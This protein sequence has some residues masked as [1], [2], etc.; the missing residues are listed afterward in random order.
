MRL[1]L[2]AVRGVL[3]VG[4][5]VLLGGVGAW[6][7]LRTH[8]VQ[9]VLRPALLDYL[10][11]T[12]DEEQRNELYDKLAGGQGTLWDIAP[13]PL[14]GRLAKR[15]GEFVY[16]EALVRT[17]NAGMR[18]ARPYTAKSSDVFRIVCLGDSFV[19][20]EGGREEDRFCN[21][22][23]DFYNDHG[24]RPDGRRVETYALGLSSWTLL[25]EARYLTRSLTAYDPDVILVLTSAN[26]ITDAFGVTGKGTLTTKF[27]P[28]H[29]DWGS[30][31][32][33]NQQGLRLGSL[34][35][36]ALT[37]D[38]SP[39]ARA[40]WR[41][42]MQQL[43]ELVDL[44]HR[45]GKQILLSLLLY[46]MDGYFVHTYLDQLAQARVDAPVLMTS[47]F[48]SK[49]TQLP[50][51]RHP[52]RAGHA[53]LAD[54]LIH[55]LSALGWVPVPPTML[56]PLDERLSLDFHHA[57]KPDALARH[58]ADYVREHLHSALDFRSFSAE[59]ARGVLGGLLL[60][61]RPSTEPGVWAS[62]RSA[63]LLRRGED[64]REVEI[65][66]VVPDRVE[67][68]PL[69]IDLTLNGVPA[70]SRSIGAA[71]ANQSQFLRAPLP[72]ATEQ[73]REV[74][75][76]LLEASSHFTRIGD[77]TMRSFRLLSARAF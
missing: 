35:P 40:R 21:Q 16:K 33:S 53:I 10:A 45:R 30:A 43:A 59:D 3:V 25:Q 57:A 7:A 49:A 74:V 32:F 22:L 67:L 39:E 62:V 8:F 26:D 71:E 24:I 38:L 27:S 37:T 13:D 15:N 47:F 65:E 9:A 14:V 4:W 6:L 34:E 46:M 48:A 50:H 20:G 36:T 2:G 29:R 51:D 61:K 68:L 56:P 54:H 19:F 58:R 12:L 42:G 66:L 76:V 28:E 52:N 31:V 60:S 63:F 72:P 17:N 64:A 18:S 70:L 5:C 69:Q 44:Q 55:A 75:E 41:S 23:E 11:S 73:D 1:K 77:Q